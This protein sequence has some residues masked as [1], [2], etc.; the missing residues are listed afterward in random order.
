MNKQQWLCIT[1][2]YYGALEKRREVRAGLITLGGATLEEPV[3]E[4]QPMK[5]N[6]SVLIVEADTEEEVRKC[7]ERDIY[8]TAGIWDAKK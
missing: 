1:P 8:Y 2:D 5:I 4:G 7:L 3:R 6:G